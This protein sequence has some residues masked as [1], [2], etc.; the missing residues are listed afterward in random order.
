M[1]KSE[2]QFVAL[3]EEYKQTIY[4]VCYLFSKDRAE[5]E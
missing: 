2:E 5:V 1:Q 4:M 3:V